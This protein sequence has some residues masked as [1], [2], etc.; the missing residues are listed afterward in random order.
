MAKLATQLLKI[1]YKLKG[2]NHV[3]RVRSF[4]S[5]SVDMFEK[6]PLLQD[7]IVFQALH[8]MVF[9]KCVSIKNPAIKPKLMRFY[10]YLHAINPR[11]YEAV[12]GNLGGVPSIRWMKFLN[13]Q[14][15][16]ILYL[17]I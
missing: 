11:A 3:P 5:K 13:A 4:L 6:Y 17:R 9:E 15:K 16:I 8:A 10:C 2:T 14:G 12:V 1:E 7:S